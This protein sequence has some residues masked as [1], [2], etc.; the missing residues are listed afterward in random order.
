MLAG[1]RGTG[2][3]FLLAAAGSSLAVGYAEEFFFRLFAQ[4]VLVGAGLPAGA[5][6]GGLSLLFGAS[7]GAQGALGAAAATGLALIL[8]SFRRAGRSA[9]A[10]CLGHALYD[11]IVLTLAA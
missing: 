9:H 4:D 8:A 3:G 7:H 5:V 2:A 6:V 11:F 10:L 1:G